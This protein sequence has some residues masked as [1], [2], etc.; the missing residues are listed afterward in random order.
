[1]CSHPSRLQEKRPSVKKYDCSPVCE[2]K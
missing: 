1:L 2:V